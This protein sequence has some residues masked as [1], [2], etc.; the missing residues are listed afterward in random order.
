MCKY[1][2]YADLNCPYSYAMFHRLKALDLL[3]RVEI[4]LVEHAQDIG[5][6]GNTPDILTEL[7]SDVFKVRSQAPEVTIALPPERP[8]SRF[9]NLCAIAAKQID[10]SKAR[11]FIDLFYNALW[12]EGQDIA[13]PTV[14]YEALQTAGLPTELSIDMDTEDQLDDWQE[15]WEVAGV[16]CRVPAIVAE[17]KR[18]LVGLAT[19]EELSAFMGGELTEREYTART[20][21]KYSDHHT[22]AIFAPNGIEHVWQTIDGLRKQYNILMPATLNDLKKHL[23]AQEET[24]D[25]LLI[26]GSDSAMESLLACQNL[27]QKI[28]NAFIP[29]AIINGDT[30]DAA[31]LQAYE[32]GVS[33]YIPQHRA[34]GIVKARIKM[35]L[36]LK[37]SRDI[38]ERSARIDGLTGV[39]NRRE[40]EKV[41]EM[42]WRRASRGRQQ[43]SLI[44]ID[45]DHFKAFNDHYGHLAGDSCLRQ[46]AGAIQ[47]ALNRSHDAVFRYGGEEF[48][49]LL[50]ETD[51]LGA[52]AVAQRIRTD[53]MS[54]GI[55]HERSST[56][57]VVTASQG[58]CALTPSNSHSPHE[59]VEKA[60]AALYKAKGKQRNCVVAA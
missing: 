41:L 11:T 57:L 27:I 7:A 15:S 23:L 38:L 2:V 9:A 19:E 17:D 48:V 24:P 43:L 35:M 58:V 5:L 51:R 36:E 21:C 55:K 34:V 37:R 28:H 47:G 16:G 32:H 25:L 20:L 30:D 54:L 13:S 39:N 50:P 14:I 53:I 46:V 45:V 42:E 18:T 12:V 6:Y 56:G 60:D 33:D 22:L 59:L 26:D 29:I 8:D 10:Q 40:F 44:L 52:E 31:E 4:R 49:V 3:D 1:V